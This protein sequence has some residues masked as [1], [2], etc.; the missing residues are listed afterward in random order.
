VLTTEY[1]PGVHLP[2]FLATNPSQAL[3]NAFG[4]KMCL[5]WYRLYYGQM[6][7]A[8]PHSGNYVF[9]NDGRLGLLDFGCVR[10][11]GPEERELQ[12]LAE[13]LIDGTVSTREF[14]KRACYATAED[15]A[16]EEYVRVME[17]SIAWGAAPLRE[18][19]FDYGRRGFLKDGVDITLRSVSNKRYA[20]AHPMY[21]Y[22]SR[23]MLGE[24]ALLY[25]LRAKFDAKAI[26]DR[27][28]L[29]LG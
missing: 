8:D 3:R 22:W 20:K 28:V 26:H 15:L 29:R 19:P 18:S 16:N 4:A 21:V 14:L 17:E 11:Y 2:A 7:Y 13:R 25:L 9:M 12:R 23:S 10:R 1:I 27:E 24:Y 5:A 6:S